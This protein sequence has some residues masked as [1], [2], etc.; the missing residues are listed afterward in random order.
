MSEGNGVYTTAVAAAGACALVAAVGFVIEKRFSAAVAKA[1]KEVE[2][3]AAERH[4]QDMALQSYYEGG[5][6]PHRSK[7]PSFLSLF[8]PS[9]RSSLSLAGLEPLTN[10]LLACLFFE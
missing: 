8:P 1:A 9:L 10:F 7:P 2:T 4:A 6:R 3:S 5:P